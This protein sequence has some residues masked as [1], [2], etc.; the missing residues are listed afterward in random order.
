MSIEIAK[1]KFQKEFFFATPFKYVYSNSYIKLLLL[2]KGSAETL[3]AL[4]NESYKFNEWASAEKDAKPQ[5]ISRRTRGRN[6]L[7]K[8]HS[9]CD[10][11]IQSVA[12][13]NPHFYT[14]SRS[15]VG[16]FT[17]KKWC[18]DIDLFRTP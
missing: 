8:V 16:C 9:D 6:V 3:W 14:R 12:S 7:Q 5:K 18:F 13:D 10:E 15:S 2:S 11:D 1:A 4:N 17:K